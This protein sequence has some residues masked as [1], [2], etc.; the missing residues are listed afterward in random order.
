MPL[1]VTERFA[2]DSFQSIPTSCFTA[3]LFANS[4]AQARLIAAVVPV[5]NG[6]HLVAAAIGLFEYSTK[7]SL[8]RYPAWVPET[9]TRW[10]FGVCFRNGLTGSAAL[11]RQLGPA[12]CATALQNRPTCFGCHS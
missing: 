10:G 11:W 3:I 5:E 12:F 4:Q 9:V 1:L 8:V 2:N 7:G 6:E